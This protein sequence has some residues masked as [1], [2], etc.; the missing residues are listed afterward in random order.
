MSE[1][2]DLE[3]EIDWPAAERGAAM[4]EREKRGHGWG[5]LRH[6]RPRPGAAED[7]RDDGDEPRP[8]PC[9]ECGATLEPPC[10]TC[11]HCGAEQLPF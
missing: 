10:E 6:P 1:P 7:R 2:L 4:R 3:S 5:S 11:P 9:D 8:F